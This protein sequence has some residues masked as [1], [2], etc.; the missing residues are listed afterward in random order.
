MRVWQ[1]GG[2]LMAQ[3]GDIEDMAQLAV[4]SPSSRA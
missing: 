2:H 4:D 1:P 3:R